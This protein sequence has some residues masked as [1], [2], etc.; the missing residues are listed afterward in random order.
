MAD[1]QT[2]YPHTPI[3]RAETDDAI[4]LQKGVAGE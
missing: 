3:T 1:P 2:P 4:G